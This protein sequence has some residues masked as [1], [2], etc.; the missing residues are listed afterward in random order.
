MTILRSALAA[1]A[2]CAS[3]AQAEMPSVHSSRT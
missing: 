2:T 1:V 3:L